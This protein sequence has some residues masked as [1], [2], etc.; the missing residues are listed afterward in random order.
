VYKKKN[1]S[2]FSHS[3]RGKS[4]VFHSWKTYLS[5]KLRRYFK[6]EDKGIKGKLP[7]K[8]VWEDNSPD[9]F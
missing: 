5:K 8:A 4:G 9:Y 6:M 2:R 1:N 3:R 7:R